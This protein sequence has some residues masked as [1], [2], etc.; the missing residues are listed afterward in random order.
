MIHTLACKWCGDEFS[1]NWRTALY[2]SKTCKHRSTDHR[3]RCPN[4]DDCTTHP[5][6]K[7]GRR[8]PTPPLEL[9]MRKLDTS[10]GL[11]SCWEWQG[12]RSELGYGSARVV[13]NG[14]QRTRP[15][16]R[17]VYQLTLGVQLPPEVFLLH[18]CDNP[19]CCNP[20][21]LRPGTHLENMADRKTRGAGYYQR[22]PKVSDEVVAAIRADYKWHTHGR[23]VPTIAAK[24]GLSIRTV[25]QI[26]NRTGRWADG[27]RADS[28]AAEVAG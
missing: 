4:G 3:R 7:E 26:V 28:I 14:R 15:A 2:C 12:W 9:L 20:A 18:Q 24:H 27:C 16:H 22:S 25:R 6:R 21:H 23:G 17:A 13:E 8:P 1:H 11:D 5:R 19:P 10:G